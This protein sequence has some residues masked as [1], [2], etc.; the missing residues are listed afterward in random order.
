MVGVSATSFNIVGRN[1]LDVF[2]SVG[3]CWIKSEF[4]CP[5]T[6]SLRQRTPVF[7]FPHLQPKPLAL[8]HNKFAC[9]FYFYM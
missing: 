2:Y 3:C 9:G 4:A 8:E 1:M 7:S 5:Q 6:F